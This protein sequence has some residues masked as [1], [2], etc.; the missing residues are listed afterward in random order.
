[1]PR[2]YRHHDGPDGHVRLLASYIQAIHGL[3]LDSP[4]CLSSHPGR[5]VPLSH[6]S[7]TLML[8]ERR[9]LSA[10]GLHLGS[11]WRSAWNL[12]VSQLTGSCAGF[13]SLMLDWCLASLTY[14]LDLSHPSDSGR[15]PVAPMLEP[16]VS[17]HY[18]EVNSFVIRHAN[19]RNKM[20]E[21]SLVPSPCP[22]WLVGSSNLSI[23]RYVQPLPLSDCSVQSFPGAKL[24][25][26]SAIL[27]RLPVLSCEPR[28]IIFNIGLNNRDDSRRNIREDLVHLLHMAKRVLPTCRLYFQ[29][30][31]IS[32]FLSDTDRHNLIRLNEYFPH[33]EN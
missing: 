3:V 22:I 25:H 2:T 14:L 17:R 12:A 23:L 20:S 24:H 15:V 31:N 26:L 19:T 13:P 27:G 11:H 29:L 33:I 28:I 32:P 5:F 18:P 4:D 1:M 7:P 30:I 16:V 10:L 6:W 21:W 9:I 8:W